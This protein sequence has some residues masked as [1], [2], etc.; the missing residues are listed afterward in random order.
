MLRVRKT[1]SAL[2]AKVRQRK[3]AM[4]PEETMLRVRR[5]ALTLG[6]GIALPVLTLPELVQLLPRGD[7]SAW[8]ETVQF[9]QRWTDEIA[10]Y[11][12]VVALIALIIAVWGNPD[13]PEDTKD[14]TE[15]DPPERDKA[16][17]DPPEQDGAEA[18]PPEQD[19]AEADPPERPADKA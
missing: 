2:A 15:I 19:K 9:I 16:E 10:K 11:L 13:D 18:D 12:F 17:A 14:L 8:P 3:A 5:T 1:A 6:I 4:F 7:E